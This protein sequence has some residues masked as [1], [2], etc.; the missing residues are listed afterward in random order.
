MSPR[1]L[2]RRKRHTRGIPSN[3]GIPK[4]LKP[5]EINSIKEYK[6]LNPDVSWDSAVE[7][8]VFES[9]PNLGNVLALA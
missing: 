1:H 2:S 5:S 3:V 6:Q 7:R 9:V 8:V 4:F